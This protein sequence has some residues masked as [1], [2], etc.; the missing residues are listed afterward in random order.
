L[1]QD[2]NEQEEVKEKMASQQF[3]LSLTV[4]SLHIKPENKKS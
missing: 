3:G 1:C 2:K 4:E